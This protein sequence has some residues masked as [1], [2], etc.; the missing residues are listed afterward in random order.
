VSDHPSLADEQGLI[1]G[2]LGGDEEALGHVLRTSQEW[3]YHVAYR[4]LG[5]EADARDA[6]QDAFLLTVRAIRGDGVPPRTTDGFRPWLRRVVVNAA[7]TQV[8]RRP[9]LHPVPVETVAE[10]L[11]GSM[12]DEPGRTTE[13]QET[14]G[15]VLQALLALPATQRAALALREFLDASYEE[16][17]EAL[18]I[19]QTAVGTL[20]YRARAGFRTSYDRIVETARPVDCPDIVPLFSAIIDEQPRPVAWQALERHLG[21]CDRCSS[22]L[23]EQRRAR[24]LYALIPLALVPAGWDPA[25]T[26]LAETLAAGL[27]SSGVDADTAAGTLADVPAV[28]L[29]ANP[30]LGSTGS[31][32]SATSVD[33]AGPGGGASAGAEAGAATAATEATATTRAATTA[34]TTAAGTAATTAGAT[35]AAAAVASTSVGLAGLASSVKLGVAALA[36]A[37]LIGAAVVAGPQ[38][39]DDAV[40]AS[41]PSPEAALDTSPSTGMA[42]AASPAAS[43]GL[44]AS[45]VTSP[46]ASPLASPAAFPSPS[47]GTSQPTTPP[48]PAGLPVEPVPTRIGSPAPAA[49]PLPAPRP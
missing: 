43:P 39:G 23:T 18:D 27:P 30:S 44:A 14:R 22:E 21:T 9:N 20:L 10:S 25:T 1:A 31:G 38:F 45:P 26:A 16:I 15:H 41:P 19:P 33:A 3:A 5:R 6:V 36:A 40:P 42:V 24:R 28:P 34:A 8:R 48:E 49:S 35:G 11:P 46:M 29:G 12:H 7:L 4:V 47:P 37:A 13:R 2:A 32:A 17:A